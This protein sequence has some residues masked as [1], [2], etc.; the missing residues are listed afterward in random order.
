MATMTISLPDD[1]SDY[2]EAQVGEDFADSGEFLAE[3]VRRDQ[4]QRLA[5]LRI[6]IEASLASGVSTRSFE[7][8]IAEGDRILR[9]RGLLNG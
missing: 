7:E 6:K 8:R 2:V 5:E 1:I 4:E 3:L 9:E